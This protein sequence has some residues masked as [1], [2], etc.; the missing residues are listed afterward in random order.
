MNIHQIKQETQAVGTPFPFGEGR[1]EAAMCNK[2]KGYQSIYIP[3]QQKTV[4][5]TKTDNSNLRL[6]K[7]L[8]YSNHIVSILL[9]YKKHIQTYG[10]YMLP[11][12]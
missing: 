3:R 12:C 10:F 9:A 11:I 8:A 1:G 7:S 5:S 4:V 6:L 2:R